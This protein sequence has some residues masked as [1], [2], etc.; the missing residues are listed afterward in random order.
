ML[1]EGK[2]ILGPTIFRFRIM[3]TVLRHP[4][5]F[6]S[7]LSPTFSHQREGSAADAVGHVANN[8]VVLSSWPD[9][10][11]LPRHCYKVK[12]LDEQSPS[13]KMSRFPAQSAPPPCKAAPKH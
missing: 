8:S 10:S 12:G 7:R 3:T 2:L 5:P 6:I 1:L 9:S 13:R 4:L 11:G